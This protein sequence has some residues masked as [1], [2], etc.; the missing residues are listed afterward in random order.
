M[1]MSEMFD[2]GMDL[3]LLPEHKAIIDFGSSRDIFTIPDTTVKVKNLDFVPWGDN[4]DLPAVVQKKIGDSEIVGSNI[5]HLIKVAYGQGVQPMIRKVDGKDSWHEPCMDEDV[6]SFFEDNDVAGFFLEQCTDLVSF[7]N[8]FPE[9]IPNA[10]FDKIV[11]LRH[12]EAVF[13]R[14]AVADKNSGN[15]IWHGYSPKWGDGANDDNTELSNVLNRYNPVLDLQTRIRERKVKVG[16]ARFI[17]PI[18]IPTPGKVYYQEPPFYSIFK[19]G[20]YDYSMMLWNTKKLLLKQGIAVRYIVYISDKYWQWIFDEE[21]IDVLN[22]EAVRD[23]KEAE[24]LRFREFLS[25]PENAGKGIMALKKMTPSGASV[26]EEK[27]ITVEE[28]KVGAKGGELLEDSSEVANYMSYA[29]GVF[30]QLVATVPG[31]NTG[32]LSGSDVR[33]KYMVKAAMM[34]PVR[35]RLLRSLYFVKKF[36]N[37]PKDLVFVVPD[38]EFTTLDQNKSGKQLNVPTNANQ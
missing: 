7:Y 38:Y 31:K 9:V 22:K 14:W 2:I 6:L 4:N 8:V 5:D 37:W 24:K 18:N 10:G 25:K 32:S 34:A 19:S 28:I 16:D 1:F 26:V 13:S 27:Y 12:K 36:N 23:R 33:E 3:S 29:M 35:D 30:T 17:I 15:I 20:S 11:S 21:G